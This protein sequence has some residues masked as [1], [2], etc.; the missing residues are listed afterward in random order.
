MK[1]EE[2]IDLARYLMLTSRRIHNLFFYDSLVHKPRGNSKNK[3]F[4]LTNYQ[5]CVVCLVRK[6]MPVTVTRLSQLLGISPPSV[7]VVVD[8]LVSKGILRRNDS[9]EDRRK[10]KL[11][12]LPEAIEG[13]FYL[14]IGKIAH[15]P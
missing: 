6:E 5:L 8:D 9:Y 14:T 11:Y 2:R 1:R 7:S 15:E 12:I 4:V 3:N 10:R 13:C